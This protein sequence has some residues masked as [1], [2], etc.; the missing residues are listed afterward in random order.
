MLMP[1][2]PAMLCNIARILRASMSS[3]VGIVASSSLL[4]INLLF[5]LTCGEQLS[6]AAQCYDRV[7]L[8]A[9]Q[10]WFTAQMVYKY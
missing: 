7:Q 4:Q 8:T 6:L 5:A 3:V 10:L 2:Q 1:D 9:L